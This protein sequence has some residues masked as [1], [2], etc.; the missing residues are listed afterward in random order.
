VQL[1]AVSKGVPVG[2]IAEAA[3]AGVRALGEN[4][5]QEADAKVAALPQVEWHLVGHL[6]GNK[7]GRALDLFAVIESVD[8]LGLAQ[9]LDRLAGAERTQPV[10][11]QVN[12]DADPAKSGFPVAGFDAQLETVLGLPSL[13]VRG[14]MTVGRQTDRPDDARPTF[15]AL[16]RL[17]ERLRGS[18]PALGPVLSMGMTDD[19]E[20]AIEEGS[21]LVRVGR[22]IFGER[23]PA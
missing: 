15:V 2:R 4:R 18:Y 10:L 23:P 21:T 1:V 11:L 14:L 9:R 7:A 16:R 13:E 20:V 12:V 5:V 8:S 3:G 22:A 19:F 17:S 6:Q